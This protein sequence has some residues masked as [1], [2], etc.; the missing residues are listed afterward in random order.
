[1]DHDVD[2]VERGVQVLATAYVATPVGHLA[3]A[4]GGGVELAPGHPDH[5]SDAVV[6]L[7]QRHEGGAEGAGRAGHGHGDA[8]DRAVPDPAALTS[9]RAAAAVAPRSPR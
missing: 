7:E 8:H 3:P 9:A 2:P 5:V 1:V 6:G 4:A